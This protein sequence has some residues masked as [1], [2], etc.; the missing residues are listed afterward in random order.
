[1]HRERLIAGIADLHVG[2]PAGV[3][4]IIQPDLIQRIA[5]PL[6]SVTP[7]TGWLL[8]V[9]LRWLEACF[10]RSFL[11]KRSL[12]ISLDVPLAVPQPLQERVKAS[13][14]PI[15][16]KYLHNLRGLLPEGL[17][18]AFANSVSLLQV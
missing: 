14:Y 3:L 6:S 18:L 11:K 12:A 5:V 13:G 16:E 10:F 8:L 1:M 17:L 7:L 2:I 15:Y 9:Q 4:H